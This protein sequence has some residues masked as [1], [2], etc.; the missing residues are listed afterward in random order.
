MISNQTTAQEQSGYGPR[1]TRLRPK[2]NQATAKKQPGYDQ[3]ATRLRPKS[4]Q[5]TAK[6]QPGYGKMAAT[7]TGY[8]KGRLLLHEGSKLGIIRL[9]KMNNTT[10]VPALMLGSSPTY[11][12]LTELTFGVIGTIGNFIVI[13]VILLTPEM[14]TMTNYLI[15]NLAFADFF[16]SVLLILNKYLTQAF[17]LTVPKGIAG[18]FYC[19]LYFSAVCFWINIKVSTFNLVLVTFER[20]FAI[21]HPLAYNRYYTSCRV[22]IMVVVAWTMAVILEV[23]FAFFHR[24][25]GKT[26]ILFDYPNFSVAAF[27]G[28]WYFVIGYLI[29]T[30]A[31][32]WAYWKILSS[33][34][35]EPGQGISV[36]DKRVETLVGARKRLIK[37][38]FL[39]LLA[40][41]ICWTPDS[42]LFLIHNLG[43]PTDYYSDYF[44]AIIL[45]AFA[46]SVLNP[47]IY[48]FK[49]KQFRKCML[50]KFCPYSM[51]RNKINDTSTMV[52][53]VSK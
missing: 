53:V 3:R 18:E 32:V 25:D 44:N 35:I 1:A 31:M 12:H 17:D 30:V 19:R 8:R 26:C 5:A 2:S 51:N 29:P 45:L 41:F 7:L 39:V 21:V 27:F 37:M 42:C 43:G 16:T 38:L 49:Y 50:K 6:E 23:A 47:F 36:H 10:D 11:I 34:T 22:V 14:R 28:V 40:Y 52:E 13:I 4:N 20:Y 48:A 24:Y 33:L 46:N 9:E 15:L